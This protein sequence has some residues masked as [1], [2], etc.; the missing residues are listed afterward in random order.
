M[1]V[2][3]NLNREVEK[4][5]LARAQE[6]GVSLDD[7][8]Q[9]LGA[10]GADLVAETPNASRKAPARSLRGLLAKYG[11]APS[12]QEIDESGAEMLANFQ[13]TDFG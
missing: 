6:R 4:R 3:L 7:Y 5:L 2:T 10:K 12:A 1:N 11:T 8:L 13:R 9:E